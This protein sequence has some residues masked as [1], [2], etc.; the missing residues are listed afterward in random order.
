[1]KITIVTALAATL[2]CGATGAMAQAGDAER[3]QRYFNSHCRICHTVAPGGANALGPDL[4]GVFGRKAGATPGY[5]SSEAMAKS[6]I[7]WN[8]QTLAEFLAAPA[9]RVPET[10]MTVAGMRQRGEIDDVVA[11]LKKV[12]P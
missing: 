1:M 3:G 6:G 11:F 5:S 8:D 7:V 4:A 10:K 9:K 2:V 12:S